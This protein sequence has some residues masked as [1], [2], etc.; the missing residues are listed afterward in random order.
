[1][2]G[3]LFRDIYS[4]DEDEED[5][6]NEWATLSVFYN[7]DDYKTIHVL[8]SWDDN[9]S[10]FISHDEWMRREYAAGIEESSKIPET[11]DMD[12]PF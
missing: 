4:F 1:M 9:T 10:S 8:L 2:I 11:E 7:T 6:C 12:V 3:L 5:N